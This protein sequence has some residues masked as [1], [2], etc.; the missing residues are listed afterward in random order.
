MDD[1]QIFLYYDETSDWRYLR[2][3]QHYHGLADPEHVCS[4]CIHYSDTYLMC[5][6]FGSVIEDWPPDQRGCGLY[7]KQ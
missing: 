4:S 1:Q 2:I 6:S 5:Y 3:M 7:R